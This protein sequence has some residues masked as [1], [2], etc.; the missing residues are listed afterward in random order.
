MTHFEI[1]P[2]NILKHRALENKLDIYARKCYRIMMDINQAEAHM[3]NED[4]YKSTGQVP[5]SEI[6][7]RRQ[8]QFIGHCLRME[9]SEPANIYALYKSEISSNRRG[10]PR[11]S[12]R[13]KVYQHLEHLILDKEQLQEELTKIANDKKLWKS[14]VMPK[15]PA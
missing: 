2:I 3:T 15:K 10:K 11:L 9:T 13:D 14:I 8:L 4:L 1:K 7:K 12:Y 5:I 6:I